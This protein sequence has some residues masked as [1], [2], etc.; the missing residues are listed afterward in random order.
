MTAILNTTQI[1]NATSTTPNIT[2]DTAGNAQFG[3]MPYGGSSFLRNRIINGAM[4]FAQRGTSFSSPAVSSYTLDR[5]A[6]Y[7][8]GT[9]PATV[10]Q[11]AGPAGYRYALQIT[12]ATGN[13]GTVLIQKIESYNCSDLSGQTVTIQ[14]DIAVSS[15]QTVQWVLQYA[16]AQDNF[17]SLTS[18]TSGTWSATTTATT[19]TATITGLPSGATNGL[20][21]QIAP[22]NGGAFTSGTITITGV[23][24]ELGSVATPFERRQYGHELALCQRY[25]VRLHNNNLPYVQFAVGRAYS[26]TNGSA[27]VILPVSMRT[28]PTFGYT[29][30]VSGNFDYGATALGTSAFAGNINNNY[31]VNI[32]APLTS[33]QAFVLAAANVSTYVY[34]DFSAEL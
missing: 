9:A 27:N 8:S 10:A 30:P 15:A 6:V 2:L 7:S 13:T 29:T 23:Q 18:I 16:T 4:D 17:G 20:Q 32:T 34:I 12:G 1:Q 3:G 22:Q 26:T 33:G 31:S 25:Y 14:A 24:L 19:F 11:V 28:T 21:L 5:W